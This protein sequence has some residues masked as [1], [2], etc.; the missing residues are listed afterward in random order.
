MSSEV[1]ALGVADEAVVADGRDAF[2]VDAEHAHSVVAREAVFAADAA[3]ARFALPVQIVCS[4]D[5]PGACTNA[6][7]W[8]QIVSTP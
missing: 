2:D 4:S 8:G 6:N 5:Q 1:A 3:A 7:Y